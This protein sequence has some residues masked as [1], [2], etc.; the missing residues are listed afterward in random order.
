MIAIVGGDGTGSLARAAWL[1]E[2][3]LEQIVRGPRAIKLLFM[4]S[5]EA[6]KHEAWPA[7]EAALEGTS[8]GLTQA[9]DTMLEVVPKGAGAPGAYSCSLMLHANG[10]SVLAM[11]H[12]RQWAHL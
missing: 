6:I 12:L 1:Q 2:Q 10:S 8:A 4:S 11:L 3:D 9:V 5:E 7:L